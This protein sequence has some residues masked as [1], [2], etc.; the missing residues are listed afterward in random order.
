ML[1]SRGE[2]TRSDVL[3]AG[4]AL[5]IQDIET[6]DDELIVGIFKARLADAPKQEAQMRE[7]L[8]IV[9]KH[10]SSELILQTARK[11]KT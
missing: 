6:A 11:G 9:G 1:R 10:R 3:E 7:H 5:G 8:T 2:F 4:K